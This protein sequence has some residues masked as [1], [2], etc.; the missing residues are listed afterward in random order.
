MDKMLYLGMTGAKYAQLAQTVTVN[1]LANAAT[2]GF[3]SDFQTLMAQQVE[4][5]GMATRVNSTMGAKGMNL[6][7]G[8]IQSTGNPLDVAINGDAWLAVRAADGSEAYTRRGDLHLTADGQLLN[9]ANQ[10]VLGE[11]GPIAVPPHQSL[12]IG[13]DGSVS[14]IPLGQSAS[15]LAVVDRI[16]MVRLDPA[17][18]MKGDDGLIR[19]N[20]GQ[21]GQPATGSR[22]QSGSLEGSNV[23]PVEAMVNLI[24]MARQFDWQMNVMKTAEQ[25]S[26]S[27]NSITRLE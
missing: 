3:R 11:G 17:K 21:P 8:M 24:G 19:Q 13:G 23:S 5:A 4:G 1:N 25:M 6:E 9:G 20:D 2:P 26:D 16:K 10:V 12:T 27:S 7:P 18:V 14:V 22:L 15:T